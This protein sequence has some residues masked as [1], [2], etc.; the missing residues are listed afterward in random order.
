MIRPVLVPANVVL[1]AQAASSGGALVQ[2]AVGAFIASLPIG[3]GI[4][5]SRLVQVAHD[6]DVLVARVSDV[7]VNGIAA[8]LGV[9][10]FGR[11][12]VGT[13]TVLL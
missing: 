13:V 7:T 12:V 4:V 6:S 9:P 8:D 5:L 3:T 10:P 2:A 11:A 1:R